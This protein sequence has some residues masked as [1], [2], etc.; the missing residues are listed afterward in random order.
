MALRTPHGSIDEPGYRR[1]CELA[2][3]WQEGGR[4]ALSGEPME[5]VLEVERIVSA[6]DAVPQRPIVD[7]ELLA[8][9]AARITGDLGLAS[10]VDRV[11][12]AVA[13]YRFERHLGSGAHAEVWE[14]I[15]LTPLGRRV[16]LKVVSGVASQLRFD[17]ERQLHAR[18]SHSNIARV[19][20]TGVTNDG[21]PYLAMELL[22]GRTFVD[23]CLRP[24]IPLRERV[25]LFVGACRGVQLAH[26]RGILHRDLKPSNILVVEENGESLAKVI[27]FGVAKSMSGQEAMTHTG[28]L[29]GTPAYM[30][31]EQLGF[32]PTADRAIDVRSDVYGLGSVLF[33]AVVGMPR[34]DLTGR[35]FAQAIRLMDRT[36]P[37]PAENGEGSIDGDLKAIIERSLERTPERRFASVAALVEDLERWL[38]GAPVLS[39]PPSLARRLM[40]L[41][42]RHRVRAAVIVSAIVA[43]AGLVV[44]GAVLYVAKERENR[45]LRE[46]STATVQAL[47]AL[48]DVPGSDEARDRLSALVVE[49]LR[50]IVRDDDPTMLGLWADALCRRSDILRERGAIAEA[51]ELRTLAL[52]AATRVVELRPE[53]AVD[54]RRM[55]RVMVLLG[56]IARETSQPRIAE[57]RYREAHAIFLELATSGSDDSFGFAIPLLWSYDRLIDLTMSER[58][59]DE[60]RV[61]V[62]AMHDLSRRLDPAGQ[63]VDVLQA[64]IAARSRAIYVGTLH[65]ERID[66]LAAREANLRDCTELNRLSPENRTYEIMHALECR[67][68]A[69]ERF[70]AGDRARS[71]ELFDESFVTLQ[72]LIDREPGYLDGWARLAESKTVF[73]E[74]R[75]RLGEFASA[76]GAANE[77][78][79]AA[80]R[81]FTAQPENPAFVTARRL[82]LAA[83]EEARAHLDGEPRS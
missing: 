19:F 61:L 39:R 17:L 57:S 62:D 67:S 43:L 28:Q 18:L 78:A 51:A 44:G 9:L 8:A 11:P 30:S 38:S 64:R 41:A 80:E 49:E 50:G 34:W 83:R 12:P 24:P 46:W 32:D 55:A 35:S 69:V 77:A 52:D 72:R 29:V 1:L 7:R 70:A 40:W 26:E 22:S 63:E 27:D 36:E 76:F 68:G 54:R 10:E 45:R 16:A 4:A 60:A 75:L 23:A 33:E 47:V 53:S 56:D 58:R 3:R 14:A 59:V 79:D 21:R 2:A 71:D 65:G 5:D 31:P 66:A 74:H 42:R 81:A 25:R 82:A 6:D 13:G 15:E 48:A 20:G 37:R 73:A